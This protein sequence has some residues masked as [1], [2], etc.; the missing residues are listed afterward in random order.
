MAGLQAG[1]RPRGAADHAVAHP[2][3]G[4]IFTVTRQAAGLADK[5]VRVVPTR[6]VVEGLVALFGYDGR[7]SAPDNAQAMD[8]ESSEQPP[9]GDLAT[10]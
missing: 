10:P 7:G 5:T 8:V 4:T 6:G 2:V 1:Q 3:E 9:G